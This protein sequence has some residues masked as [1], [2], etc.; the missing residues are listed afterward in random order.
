M[1]R[2]P[3]PWWAA[4]AG[5]ACCLF[6]GVAPAALAASPPSEITIGTL[7][8][9]EGPFAYSSESEFSGLKFWVDQENKSGG[10]EVK[11][12]GK[13]IPIKVIAYDD[14]SS[15]TTA[16][17]LYN[18]L[19]TQDKV[20]ILV[21][22]NGSVLTSVAVPL[23]EEQKYLLFDVAGTSSFF[24]TKDNPYIVLT[25]MRTSGVWPKALAGFLISRKIDRIAVLYDSNDFAGSQA[26]TIRALLTEAG[27]APVYYHAVPTDTSNYTVLLR[28]IAATH[29]NAVLEFGYPNNDIAFLNAL[30]QSGL[31]FKMVYT[32]YPGQ[33]L[34]LFLKNV[35]PQTLAYT[36]STVTPPIL[37]NNDVNYGPGIDAFEKAYEAATGKKVNFQV[38]AGYTAGL[39]I[40][41]TLAT[42]TSLGQM[43]LRK[44][45]ASLSGKLKT[46]DGRFDVAPNGAQIGETIPLGQFLGAPSAKRSKLEVVY[47][48]RLSTGQAEYP[49]PAAH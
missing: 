9:S 7:Y 41:K 16:T 39:V 20:N 49:A 6:L 25:S 35:S 28:T 5:A 38:I 33:Q 46:L 24:F 12:F 31:H 4:L 26:V 47:P 37:R 14:L 42:A 45:V 19:I 15:T 8:A 17:N 10:V 21:A 3:K 44:A 23:A 18:Q 22:D 29:P 13:K 2:K 40:G 27:D 32:V 43:A 34:A 48:Q 1:G 11:A 30:A 36:F